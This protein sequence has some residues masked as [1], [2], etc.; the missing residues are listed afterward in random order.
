MSHDFKW[1]SAV[2]HDAYWLYR[3][4]WNIFYIFSMFSCFMYWLFMRNNKQIIIDG[5]NSRPVHGTNETCNF[6][7]ATDKIQYFA[8]GFCDGEWVKSNA[9]SHISCRLLGRSRKFNEWF[10]CQ[11]PEVGPSVHWSPSDSDKFS[12]EAHAVCMMCSVAQPPHRHTRGLL[13]IRHPADSSQLL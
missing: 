10:M 11:S 1:R 12:I 9:L 3:L 13:Y 5:F 7:A 2:V 8:G 4:L 6:C